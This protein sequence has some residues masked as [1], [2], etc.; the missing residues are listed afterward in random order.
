MPSTC[1]LLYVED[2]PEDQRMLAEAA[3]LATVS[4]CIV[5][6]SSAAEATRRLCSDE[7]YDVLLLDWNLPAVTGPEFLA[8]VRV[9]APTLPVL[10]ISGEPGTVD[11]DAAASFGVET[12]VRKPDNL[13]Q[14]EELARRLHSFCKE[15]EAAAG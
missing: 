1:R 13:D 12:I 2:T 6:V 7:A 14:W 15:V 10:V 8:T 11:R 5:P 3:D 9:T 4:I